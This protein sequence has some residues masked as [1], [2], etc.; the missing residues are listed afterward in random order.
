MK[1]SIVYS[2]NTGNT[3]QLAEAIKEEIK[4]ENIIYFGNVNEK[5]PDADLYI[6]GSW[7]DKG[8]ASKD[9]I[10]FLK[11]LKDKKI[12]YFGTAGY[13]GGSEYY[14]I[15][16]KRIKNDIDSSNIILGHFYCQ[17]RMPIQVK[18]KYIEMITKNP[19]DANLKVNI[20]NFEEALSHPDQT[21]LKN[22]RQWINKIIKFNSKE[23]KRK[24][25]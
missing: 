1:I 10:E 21:D 12:I 11:T 20:K 2:S 17:G 15:L 7:T 14:D 8:N 24:E 9:I 19:E 3:K 13:G 4:N 23:E 18:E 25:E 6:I 16:F 22:V 5:I